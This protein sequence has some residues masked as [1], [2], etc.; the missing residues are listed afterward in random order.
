MLCGKKKFNSHLWQ[1]AKSQYKVTWRGN[2][3]GKTIKWTLIVTSDNWTNTGLD[4]KGRLDLWVTYGGALWKG[5][6]RVLEIVKE[7]GFDFIFP[8]ETFIML[9]SHS[10]WWLWSKLERP[11]PHFSPWSRLT[12]WL[13]IACIRWLSRRRD[14]PRRTTQI[15]RSNCHDNLNTHKH[16]YARI[17]YTHRMRRRQ[18]GLF[19]ASI[20]WCSLLQLQK[21]RQSQCWNQGYKNP[22]V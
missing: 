11:P 1:V 17:L 13:I 2:T 19:R 14:S 20:L 22:S 8:P 21:Q 10:A 12:D 16:T 18:P 15:L 9:P 7:P 3:R 5:T 6:V 4:T